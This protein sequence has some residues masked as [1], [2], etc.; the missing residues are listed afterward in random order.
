MSVALNRR[1]EAYPPR[2]GGGV[3]PDLRPVVGLVLQVDQNLG[4]RPP[5]AP[6]GWVRRC[7]KGSRH[8]A[9]PTGRCGFVGTWL[10]TAGHLSVNTLADSM[11]R[12]G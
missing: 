9:A 5:A 3:L 11:A 4:H 1:P 7:G 12:E 2:P 6:P 10:T 8:P